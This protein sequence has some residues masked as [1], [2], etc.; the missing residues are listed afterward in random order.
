MKPA[1]KLSK[2]YLNLVDRVRKID[3]NAADYLLYEAPHLPGFADYP[4]LCSV[5]AWT[6]TPQGHAYWENIA[7]QLG[8]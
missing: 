8:E 1:R 7:Q 5:F 6:E 4:K 3:E 2:R